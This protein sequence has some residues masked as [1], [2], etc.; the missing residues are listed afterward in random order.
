MRVKV[1]IELVLEVRENSDAIHAVDAVLDAGTLQDAL[2]EANEGTDY[3][4][5]KVVSAV[6]K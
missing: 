1:V 2:V 5:V 3:A 4:S 6:S